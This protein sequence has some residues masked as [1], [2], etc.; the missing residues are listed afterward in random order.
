MSRPR[1]LLIGVAAVIAAVATASPPAARGPAGM[2][3]AGAPVVVGM[4]TDLPDPFPIARVRVTEAQLAD[5]AKALAPGPLTRLPRS[6][7]EAKVRAAGNAVLAGKAQPRLVEA[8]YTAAAAGAS[9]AGTVEWTITHGGRGPALLPLDP[10]KLA[11]GEPVWADGAPA[12]VGAFTGLP[13]GVGVWVPGPG[14]HV[15]RA[16]WTAAASG[17]PAERVFDLRLP[18]CP[19]SVL[20]L[21][22]AADRTPTAGPDVLLTGPLH[23][24][25]AGKKSW[26]LRFGEKARPDLVVRGPAGAG[27][28]MPV[29]YVAATRY[30]LTPGEVACEFD[31]DLRA[32]REP[33][34]EWAFAPSPGLRVLEVTVNN[35]A[36]WRTDAVTNEL[37]VSL[38]QPAASAK[39]RVT[40]VAALRAGAG[41]PAPLPTLRPVD[42]LPTQEQADVHV[43]AGLDLAGWEPGDF[44]ITDAAT[45]ADGGR[46][47]AMAGTLL[48]AGSDQPTRRP[49]AVRVSDAGPLFDSTEDVVWVADA[50]P[51]HLNAIVR[52]RVRRGPLFRV[53]V[54]PTPGFTLG[55]VTTDP[56]DGLASARPGPAGAVTVEFARPLAA[57]QEIGLTLE[58]RGPAVPAGPVARL[59]FP[60]VAVVGA[61]ERQGCVRVVAAPAWEAYPVVPVL[62]V[63]HAEPADVP[64]LP[65]ESFR[66]AYRGPEPAGYLLLAAVRPSFA[67]SVDTRIDFTNGQMTATSV[68][69]LDV[70]AG[71][72]GGV[73]VV[74]PAGGTGRT[75]KVADGSNTVAAATSARLGGLSAAMALLGGNGLG[76]FAAS[77]AAG[78]LEPGTTWLVRFARPVEGELVL[79]T[80]AVLGTGL[81]HTE[82][83]RRAAAWTG[84][85]VFGASSRATRTDLPPAL[86]GAAHAAPE[87]AEWVVGDLVLTT[88]CGTHDQSATLRGT[89]SGRGGN[90]LPVRIP[91]GAA[92][93]WATVAGKLVDP[94]SLARTDLR[95]PVPTGDGPVA[96]ELRYRLPREPRGVAWQVTSPLPEVAGATDGARRAWLYGPGVTAAWPFGRDADDTAVVIPVPLATAAGFGLAALVFGLGWVGV[97]S[98]HRSAGFALLTLLAAAGVAV[99]VGPAAWARVGWPVLGVGLPAAL[100]VVLV[101]GR[102]PRRAAAVA[103]IITAAVGV[104]AQTGGA[105][106]VLV[107]T[108]AD[109]ETVLAPPALLDRLEA[110]ANPAAPAPVV[111][112]AAY[113]GRVDDGLAR[114]TAAYTV[115]AFGGG[116]QSVLLPLAD[117]RLERVAVNGAAANPA[118]LG[119]GRYAVPLPGPGRHAV[120][121]RFAVPVGGSVGEREV[122]FGVPEVP[123]AR[124][125]FAAPPAARQVQAVGRFGEQRQAGDPTRIAA[126]LGALKTVSVRWRD[127]PTGAGKTTV[128]EGCVWDVS[129]AGAVL[130]ACYDIRPDAAAGFRFDLPPGLEPVRVAA[131]GLDAAGGAA[132]VQS[133]DVT[134][135]KG[136]GR[137]LR[138]DLAAPADGRVLV[139]VE[140]HARAAPT[141]QPVLRFPKPLGMQPTGGV[142]GLRPAGVTVGGVPRA[143]VIDFAADGLVREFGSVP[144]L[145]LVLVPGLQ[146]FSPRPDGDPPELRP[147]LR[148]TTDPGTVRLEAAWGADVRVAAGAG[149]LT[150]TSAE[151][152]AL[153]EFE[154]AARVREIRSA[155]LA[156]WAQAGE[157]VQVWFRKP[158]TAAAVEWFADAT[159]GGK[160]ADEVV[161]EPPL[162]RPIGASVGATALRVRPAEGVGLAVERDAGWTAERLGDGREWGFKAPGA[163][164][165]V[166]VQL[167][168]TRVGRVAGCG[169]LDLT[170]T[171]PTYR[172]AVDLPVA[173]GRPANVRV[174]V[175]GLP[176]GTVPEF[177]SLAGAKV[178]G[179][180]SEDDEAA[181]D[182]DLP[183]PSSSLRVVVSVRLP[184]AWVG[185]LPTVWAGAG[186]AVPGDASV[187]RFVG[188]I[189]RP[190]ARLIG[191]T[192]ATPI[193]YAEARAIWPGEVERLRRTGGELFSAGGPVTL[194]F[195]APAPVPVLP[196]ASPPPVVTAPAPHAAPPPGAAEAAGWLLAMLAVG[197]LF[198]RL[199]Q[200][201]WPEQVAALAALFGHAV[202]G[203]SFVGLGV[204]VTA[205]AVWAADRWRRVNS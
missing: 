7:F 49:P 186:D 203:V 129:E 169:L 22:L 61:A 3:A 155:D 156:G 160:G 68:V 152:A 78:R 56:A 46:V 175:S 138:V 43:A 24:A 53:T 164:A 51:T 60:G 165:P 88:E 157:R 74:D 147:L 20:D 66:H 111:A 115:Q 16:K 132:A 144:E 134:A 194:E 96:V 4:T 204:W 90:E 48:P 126:E 193:E 27:S 44:R 98:A 173:A 36:G 122:K 45:G 42:G 39:V 52:L 97:R 205:R 40:A 54:R 69:R 34:A 84:L 26:R 63:P 83:A 5:A 100:A 201:T 107:L 47:L 29:V 172:V 137:T 163:A 167:A 35:R 82:A 181:W 19:A 135:E 110:L 190:A 94:A 188:R 10:L 6:V 25:P 114:V 195:L 176:S 91:P 59:P 119:G 146:A 93:R 113:D 148:V 55:R 189:G 142:Y 120:E 21:E 12:A 57:G 72:V 30:D 37:R 99:S 182:V 174:R 8:R 162:P 95:L 130:T 136:G 117:V 14:R 118:A 80:T 64:H 62:P 33:L 67:S 197:V 131:R 179:R 192:E 87:R 13:G 140:C 123:D 9:L 161:F 81:S 168:T 89:V 11:L 128:R 75:W 116:E 104:S 77:A 92:V 38:R 58:F 171:E 154:L 86:G 101:R 15:L 85:A 143:G 133:W 178:T 109:G 76:P 183:S 185:P 18:P 2:A 106:V 177:E 151:P 32:A 166:R 124:L 41:A 145:R 103:T 141:A 159:P 158:V 184:S 121:V 23:G 125:T 112:S 127:A 79:E 28:G 180:R 191:A 200:A 105:D 31:L 150:W 70:S 108:G 50:G 153:L 17:P 170:A 1:L 102:L 199:P 187:V 198:A 73:A 65:H 139:T 196:A 149:T 71:L 202:A